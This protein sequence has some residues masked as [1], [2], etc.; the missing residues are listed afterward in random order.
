MVMG[1]QKMIVFDVPSLSLPAQEPRRKWN[2][3]LS[4]ALQTWI[5]KTSQRKFAIAQ[6]PSTY[7]IMD[8][9][10]S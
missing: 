8:Q 2:F 1:F 3:H 6:L 4:Y 9:V 5:R 7:V 10:S